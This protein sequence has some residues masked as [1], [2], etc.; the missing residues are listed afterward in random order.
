MP[1]NKKNVDPMCHISIN[2]QLAVLRVL[3]KRIFILQVVT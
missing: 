3:N 1:H 2:V